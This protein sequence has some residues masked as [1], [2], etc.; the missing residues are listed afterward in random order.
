ME[1]AMRRLNGGFTTQATE[2]DP[3]DFG[4]SEHIKKSTT[5]AKRALKDGS[6]GSSGG[7][8]RYRGVRRRPW[9]RYA[10]EIRDPQS[11]ER[12]WLGTFDTAEEAACAYDCAA[13][14]MRGVKAR[15]NFV[16]PPTSPPHG[17]HL[18]LAA[19]EHHLLHSFNFQKPSQPSIITHELAP[20]PTPFV[21]SPTPQPQ[22]QQKNNSL[23]MFL[24]RDFINSSS[25]TASASSSSSSSKFGA[26]TTTS[27]P[28]P[29]YEP[30]PFLANSNSS[31][32]N[33]VSS[34]RN[35]VSTELYKNLPI[36]EYDQILDGV[37]TRTSSPIPDSDFIPSEPSDS[38]LLEEIIQGFLPPKSSS[39]KL[40][41]VQAKSSSCFSSQVV[42]YQSDLNVGPPMVMMES[43][44]NN[45]NETLHDMRRGIENDYFDLYFDS[46]SSNHN[47]N[48]CNY[49][50]FV[51]QP[52]LQFGN[53]SGGSGDG[54]SA[55]GFQAPPFRNDF[56]VNFPAMMPQTATLDEVMQYPPD[57]FGV[58]AAKI[59][60]A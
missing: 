4:S 48:G 55:F 26:S 51:P 10:A 37:P 1:E 19:P 44:M 33:V 59:Q 52:P 50:G 56:P 57:L 6:G 27:Q 40:D 7:T 42:D 35:T 49:Q 22:Q 30:F 5:T 45:V 16:Y 25:C 32:K 47:Q 54:G 34:T 23:N 36:V 13:R 58:F 18:P 8:M 24:L 28:Q 12:R 38:G 17:H 46:S 14:A 11:K 21:V 53:S 31:T 60:N 9:G 39:K 20:R 43:S 3:K 15:T 29:V 41:V 2:P